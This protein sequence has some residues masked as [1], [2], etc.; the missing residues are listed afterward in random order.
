MQFEITEQLLSNNLRF[1]YNLAL[2]FGISKFIYFRK[3]GKSEYVLAYCTMST[4]V[5]MLCLLIKHIELGLGFAVS[6]FAVFGI[7]RYRTIPIATREMTY[8]FVAISIGATNAL[9]PEDVNYLSILSS[10][11]YLV[12]LLF[13]LENIFVKKTKTVKKELIYSNL[14]L[15]HP[16]LREALIEDLKS[17]YGFENIRTIKTGK[18]DEIKQA[19]RLEIE[20]EA[21]AEQ[22]L[23]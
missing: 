11:F 13:F 23:D 22:H 9:V 6:I 2:V 19:V 17:K 4:I 8:L 12:V 18:I 1:L 21:M 5:F 20:F 3:N 16:D 14:K 10:H 15:I 7:I